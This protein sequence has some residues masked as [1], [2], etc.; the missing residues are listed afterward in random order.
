[1]TA[2]HG[3]GAGARRTARRPDHA[4]L[5][6][7][8]LRMDLQ[9]RVPEVVSRTAEI[10]NLLDRVV[11]HSKGALGIQNA[12]QEVEGDMRAGARQSYRNSAADA[13]AR[14]GD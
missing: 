2:D 13:A 14:S 9:D 3:L 10:Q 4:G 6:L 5:Q 12:I 1:M 11:G 7:D 8:I